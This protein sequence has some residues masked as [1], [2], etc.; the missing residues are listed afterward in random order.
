LSY[1][2]QD[3]LVRSF[4]EFRKLKSPTA[5]WS[6]LRDVVQQLLDDHGIVCIG[7]LKT[8]SIW[9]KD[10]SI[11]KEKITSEYFFN[12]VQEWHW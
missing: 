5:H 11:P 4:A 6:D 8:T 3:S 1:V 9:R 7:S 2:A 12:D 10:L